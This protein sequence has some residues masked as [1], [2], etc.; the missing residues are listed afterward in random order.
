MTSFQVRQAE[1]LTRKS[2]IPWPAAV[3]VVTGRTTLNEVLQEMVREERIKGLI[4][5]H[6]IDRALATSIALG[7]TDLQT[8][9][10]RR[11]KNETLSSNYKR[12]CLE[13][14][15]QSGAPIVVALHGHQKVRGK[16]VGLE[17]YSFS[18]QEEGSTEVVEL[19]KTLA[20]FAYDPAQY[21]ELRK[22][23]G[24]DNQVKKKNLEPIQRVKE[25]HHFKNMSLQRALDEQ[26]DV[27]V[28][29]LEGDTFRGKVSWFGRWEFG[30][31]FKGGLK[32]SVF[33]HGVYSL[34]ILEP[35]R[36]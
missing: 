18:F 10:L 36:K 21:K 6:E 28:T 23:M 22:F 13:E 27:D 30:L 1:D 3:R 32:V 20:K 5:T 11:R 7:R 35:T 19:H 31:K 2:H 12:S 25:R 9:L 29:T 16:I 8:V 34:T 33:R 15:F 26:L 14:G 4:A 17:Q 24:I